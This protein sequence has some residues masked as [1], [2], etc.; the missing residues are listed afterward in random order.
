MLNR[1]YIGSAA[2][3]THRQLNL[4]IGANNSFDSNYMQDTIWFRSNIK[5]DQGLNRTYPILVISEATRGFSALNK[6]RYIAILLSAVVVMC[7]FQCVFG[8]CLAND[9]E[10]SS[11]CSEQC[12]CPSQDSNDSTPSTPC[13]CPCTDCFCCGA[14]PVVDIGEEV[15]SVQLTSF[16]ITWMK[17][18]E[19]STSIPVA[20]VNRHSSVISVDATATDARAALSCWL[21]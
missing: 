12:G 14:L 17:I 7:P 18:D 6:S 1:I 20:Q 15:I 13:S 9:V 5:L 8:T 3:S 4:G 10:E 11:V 2:D 21:I 16:L 19:T